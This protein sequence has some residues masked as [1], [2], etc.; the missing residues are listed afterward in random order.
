MW[1]MENTVLENTDLEHSRLNSLFFLNV[2][3]KFPHV[4]SENETPLQKYLRR[5]CIPLRKK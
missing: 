5:T 2:M 4:E 1:L 3:I